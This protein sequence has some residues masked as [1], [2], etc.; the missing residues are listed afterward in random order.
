LSLLTKKVGKDVE[1]FFHFKAGLDMQERVPLST[2]SPD[3]PGGFI[4]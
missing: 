2:F 3:D 4:R 1:E